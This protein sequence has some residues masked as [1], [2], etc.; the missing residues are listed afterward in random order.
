MQQVTISVCQ[1]SGNLNHNNREF[2]TKNV[3]INFSSENITYKKESLTD[4]Y[5]FCFEKA[6]QDYNNKQTRKDRLI[7]GT[8]GYMNKLKNSKNGEKLFYECIVQIGNKFDMFNGIESIETREK[9][10]NILNDYMKDFEERNPNLYVF[11]AVLHMDETTPHLHIDYIPIAKNYKKGLEVR[12][13]LTK[14]LEEQGI[15]SNKTKYNNSSINWSIQEKDFLEKILNKYNLTRAEEKGYKRK[16]LSL[17]QYKAVMEQSEKLLN[18]NKNE[19]LNNI[20]KNVRRSNFNKNY[21]II[22]ADDFIYLKKMVKLKNSNQ[23]LKEKYIDELKK[24]KFC[25]FI[26][27]Y[28]S[29][30]NENDKLKETLENVKNENKTLAKEIM[31]L[32]ELIKNNN[33]IK[34]KIKFYQ[35]KEKFEKEKHNKNNLNKNNLT[36]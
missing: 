8:N 36:R 21:A 24:D 15:L 30:K 17:E 29:L 2:I 1:G 6:I 19:K 3:D 22:K 34:E 33:S 35:E 31:K 10:K 25:N 18:S 26:K 20:L 7:D 13:S 14:A 9:Y 23:E 4:A 16:H 32:N 5:K 28:N 12:N 27:N 11:N